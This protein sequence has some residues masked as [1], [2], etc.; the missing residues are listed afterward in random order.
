[1]TIPG[2]AS[3]DGPKP[4]D[5]TILVVD[6][7]EILWGMKLH[8]HFKKIAEAA[9]GIKGYEKFLNDYSEWAGIICGWDAKDKELSGIEMLRKVRQT[10]NDFYDV[11]FILL[12]MECS[13]TELLHRVCWAKEEGATDFIVRPYTINSVNEK[14]EL[15]KADIITNA[16]VRGKLR[17]V[18][19]LITSNNVSEAIS[20]IN[21]CQKLDAAPRFAHRIRYCK[22]R[23]LEATG[24]N[25]EA[26]AKYA[27][28]ME[29]SDYRLYA[30]ARASLIELHI[31]LNEI[32]SALEQVSEAEKIS[33]LNPRWKLLRGKAFLA[34]GK[35]AEAQEIFDAIVAA[36]RSHRKDVDEV[37]AKLGRSISTE[38]A[39]VAGN[40][41]LAKAVETA[42]LCKD[43]GL[44]SE[45]VR[46]YAKAAAIDQGNKKK[47][48]ASMGVLSYRWHQDNK[49]KGRMLNDPKPL[50]DAF[51][52]LLEAARIDP[53][54]KEAVRFMEKIMDAERAAIEKTVDRKDI[55]EAERIIKQNAGR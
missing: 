20:V 36:D 23:I 27:G 52:F 45:A 43:R 18:N 35:D 16:E 51:G 34:S 28:A 12:L 24:K 33:P 13:K 37:Y 15:M 41:E 9:D 7:K 17:R 32:Q 47:Y 46:N 55:M 26:A 50:A 53:G 1:M 10:D 11:P 40:E 49:D 29:K 38:N 19:K 2:T 8:D 21:T 4:L 48:F 44:F 6:A 31:R 30:E 42:K 25:K 3:T 5:R 39:A 14:I 54:F 22:G